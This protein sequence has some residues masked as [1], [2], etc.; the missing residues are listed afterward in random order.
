MAADD[1]CGK[2]DQTFDMGCCDDENLIFSGIDITSTVKKYLD[3][4]PL[5]SSDLTQVFTLTRLH[6]TRYKL[7]SYF[8]PPEPLAYGRNLLV[9]VQRFLI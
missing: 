4:T 5:I 1:D 9:K 8:P 7:L 6:S 3:L 2:P